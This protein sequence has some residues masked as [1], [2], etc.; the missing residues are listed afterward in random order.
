[1]RDAIK[2]LESP[3]NNL[4][5]VCYALSDLHKRMNVANY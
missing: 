2:A 5:K 4:N 1:M 3:D